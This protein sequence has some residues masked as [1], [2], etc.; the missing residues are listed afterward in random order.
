MKKKYGPI[1]NKEYSTA[2]QFA[3]LMLKKNV[4]FTPY[5]QEVNW[6]YMRRSKDVMDVLLRSVYILH[7]G[8]HLGK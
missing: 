1:G 6:T 8:G 3:W 2:G 4:T 5:T 7:S